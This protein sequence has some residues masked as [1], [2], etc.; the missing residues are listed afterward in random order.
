MNTRVVICFGLLATLACGACTQQS[1]DFLE[2]QAL[3]VAEGKKSVPQLLEEYRTEID[4]N[5]DR[6]QGYVLPA[7]L[8]DR[9]ESDELF[10]KALEID[11]DFAPARIAYS[12]YLLN[13]KV[14][15]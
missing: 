2:A 6:P 9:P 11:S 12:R 4:N 14:R 10:R 3:I 15:G 13:L 8:Y 1:D 7:T 5:P